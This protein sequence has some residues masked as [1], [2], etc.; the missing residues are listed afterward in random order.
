M[1]LIAPLPAHDA[2]AVVTAICQLA[3]AL[4]LQVVAEGIETGEQAQAALMAG[5]HELQGYF[6]ARPMM[7]D[8]ALVWLQ[9][10]FAATT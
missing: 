5:C 10:T 6:Y 2:V 8:D 4:Q 3:A 1:T 9:R 7:P